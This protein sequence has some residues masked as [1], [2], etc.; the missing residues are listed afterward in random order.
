MLAAATPPLLLP[1]L[2][3]ALLLALVLLPLVL[4]LVLVLVL[5]LLLVVMVVPNTAAKSLSLR[6]RCGS[7]RMWRRCRVNSPSCKF[8]S[9]PT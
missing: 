7:G 8:T 4:L 6:S 9:V 5:L 2:L 1:L 3:L